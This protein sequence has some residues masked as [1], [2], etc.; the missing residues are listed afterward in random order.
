M[1]TLGA[2]QQSTA[3]AASLVDGSLTPGSVFVLVDERGQKGYRSNKDDLSSRA[4]LV[5]P[6]SIIRRR[7]HHASCPTEILVE[8]GLFLVDFGDLVLDLL[9][10]T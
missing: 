10:A 4:L 1:R 2:S 9:M 5:K 6:L 3:L 8:D 7:P